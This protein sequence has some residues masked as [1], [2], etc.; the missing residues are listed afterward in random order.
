MLAAARVPRALRSLAL[1]LGVGVVVVLFWW[2]RLVVPGHEWSLRTLDLRL[3]FFPIYKALFARVL[4]GE[5]PLWNPYQ[6]CGVPW[7]GSP[8]GGLFYPPH[9][10]FVVLPS[11]VALATL[12][13]LHLVLIAVSTALLARRVGLTPAAAMAGALLFTLHGFVQTWFRAPPLLEAAAWL[14]L[15][16]VAIADVARRPGLR[17]AALLAIA[18][19]ASWLAGGPQPTVYVLYAWAAFLPAALVAEGAPAS[20]WVA[21]ALWTVAGIVVGTLVAGV[22]LAPSFEMAREG[23]RATAAL[24]L[25][26]IFPFVGGRQSIA[27][28][29][30]QST[31]APGARFGA[32]GLALVAALPLVRRRRAL[33]AW[34]VLVGGMALV[35]SL[36]PTTPLF[37]AYFLLPALAWFRNPV[38]LLFLT[39]FCFALMAAIVLDAVVG[40]RGA[41]EVGAS[42]RRGLRWSVVG[43]A[44]VLA[45]ARARAH[46][47]VPAVVA[48][49]LAVLLAGRWRTRRGVGCVAAGLLVVELF[50][51]GGDTAALPYDRAAADEYHAA[52]G[53][54]ARLRELEGDGRTWIVNGPLF[55][56]EFA[57]KLATFY[58]VRSFD[59]YESITLRRQAQYLTYLLEGRVAP[60]NRKLIFAGMVTSGL[61][62]APLDRLP[63]QRRLLDLAGVRVVLMGI[64]MPSVPAVRTL[65]DDGLRELPSPRGDLLLYENPRALPRAYVTYRVE[66]APEPDALLGRLSTPEF[67]PMATSY[68]EG[69]LVLPASA[70]PPSG[71][72]A[73]IV[74][75]DPEIVEIDAALTAPGLVVLADS[76]YPGW[77]ATVDGAPAPIVP[78]NHLFRGVP[79]AAGVHRI[80]FE[81][82][83]TSVAIGAA[84]SLLGLVVLGGLVVASAR[85]R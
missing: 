54:W 43:A 42:N 85:R 9:L 8:Q 78:T 49:G 76:F 12:G 7:L 31:L 14:P 69:G 81:Y 46:L 80:R 82:R 21:A 84:A 65:I 61:A 47:V 56:P 48:V 24:D 10:L 58:A 11:H 13:A 40:D 15:G 22:Q 23:T 20:R 4:R 25:E 83:P 17:A 41:D 77:R 71:H 27:A 37:G 74:R 1:P 3:F 33:A 45:I 26:A 62:T 68:V 35:L 6:L 38:A 19:G 73:R 34:A 50:A 57:P 16:C 44:L 39:D 52:A 63:A 30:W 36:G 70:A 32:I 51:T 75:D 2:F 79:A 5:L 59:D 60:A 67:D 64:G 29:A 18:M 53:V 55:A 28:F 66:P 72:A